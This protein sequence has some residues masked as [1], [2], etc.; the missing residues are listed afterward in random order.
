MQ[1][2]KSIYAELSLWWNSLT[3]SN[4]GWCLA[5]VIGGILILG[6]LLQGI[7]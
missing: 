6:I 1:K 5:C 7:F 3:F 2:L 4:K